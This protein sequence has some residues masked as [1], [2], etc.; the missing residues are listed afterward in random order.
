[1]QFPAISTHFA[2]KK[3]VSPCTLVTMFTAIVIWVMLGIK[4]NIIA[5]LMSYAILRI[6]S[7]VRD[8][9]LVQRMWSSSKK[10]SQSLGLI[11]PTV[12]KG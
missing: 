2:E 1:M 11:R 5:Q 12:D 7:Q 4:A 6:T 3:D 9:V 8:P 10:Q